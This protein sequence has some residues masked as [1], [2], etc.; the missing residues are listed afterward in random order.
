MGNERK[1]IQIMPMEG[2]S[3]GMLGPSYSAGIIALDNLGVVW[4]MSAE[5]RKWERMPGLPK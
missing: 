1:I 2:S 4:W 3:T 5:K